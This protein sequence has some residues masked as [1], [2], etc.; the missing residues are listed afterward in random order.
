MR[1]YETFSL[2]ASGHNFSVWH[3]TDHDLAA[4]AWMP[5]TVAFIGM[6]LQA[7]GLRY[8]L[9]NLCS[10]SDGM[11]MIFTSVLLFLLL[12]QIYFSYTTLSD[13]RL[14]S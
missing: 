3:V 6:F 7:S 11:C 10:I 1:K 9:E 5:K 13:L 4:L 14:S 8:R 2:V 12:C